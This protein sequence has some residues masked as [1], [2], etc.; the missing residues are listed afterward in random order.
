MI[1]FEITLKGF[2]PLDSDTDI[3]V[4]WVRAP[5]ERFLLDKLRTYGVMEYVRTFDPLANKVVGFAD[6]LDIEMYQDDGGL[7]HIIPSTSVFDSWIKDSRRVLQ[8]QL[9]KKYKFRLQPEREK[10]MCCVEGRNTEGCARLVLRQLGTNNIVGYVFPEHADKVPKELEAYLEG[11]E[12]GVPKITSKF[13]DFKD[14]M[15]LWL[16]NM[17]STTAEDMAGEFD[18]FAKALV[19][20]KPQSEVEKHVETMLSIMFDTDRSYNRWS[21]VRVTQMVPELSDPDDRLDLPAGNGSVGSYVDY[22]VPPRFSEVNCDKELVLDW[23]HHE[24]PIAC[25]EDVQIEVIPCTA[26][27]TWTDKADSEVEQQD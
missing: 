18:S 24:V 11:V 14:V 17:G 5:S 22:T 27:M 15:R 9:E 20:R 12:A 19:T 6:G 13:A 16:A 4:K 2:D 26:V 7:S 10:H 3:L 8:I 21:R 1:T 23:F 25:L